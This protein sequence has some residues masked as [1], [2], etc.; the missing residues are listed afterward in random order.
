MPPKN[1][2][3]PVVDDFL[4]DVPGLNVSEEELDKIMEEWASRHR[5]D[6]FYIDLDHAKS[7]DEYYEILSSAILVCRVFDDDEIRELA[8]LV[9][10]KWVGKSGNKVNEDDEHFVFDRFIATPGM[11]DEEGPPRVEAIK[12]IMKE[13][14]KTESAA[15]KLY[16]KV[17][18]SFRQPHSKR[19]RKKGNIKI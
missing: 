3:M 7:R 8:N 1:K 4:D 12:I 19:G 17:M 14:G 11:N 2:K 9:R 16:D 6:N 18:R 5:L 10:T 13:L 15:G